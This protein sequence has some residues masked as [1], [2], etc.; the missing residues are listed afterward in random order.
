MAPL[1]PAHLSVHVPLSF[2]PGP[3]MAKMALMRVT[4]HRDLQALGQWEVWESLRGAAY[5]HSS[6]QSLR[7][8]RSQKSQKMGTQVPPCFSKKTHVGGE[9]AGG[10]LWLSPASQTCP[11]PVECWTRQATPHGWR[12]EAMKEQERYLALFT[13]LG[14]GQASPGIIAD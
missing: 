8:S 11:P 6:I 9:K 13:E 3:A 12:R 4:D 1:D 10:G 5:I 14:L 2:P 7:G